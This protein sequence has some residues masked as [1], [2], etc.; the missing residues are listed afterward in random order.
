MGLPDIQRAIEMLS[1][2]QQAALLDWL[3]ERDRRQW[4]AQLERDFSP[5]GAGIELLDRVKAQIRQARILANGQG[6]VNSVSLQ[7][8]ALPEFWK[9]Y[10]ALPQGVRALADAKFA[11][12]EADPFHP[13]LA[14]VVSPRKGNG[15]FAEFVKSPPGV[16]EGGLPV[17][18]NASGGGAAG[19]RSQPEWAAVVSNYRHSRPRSREEVIH[20]MRD[21]SGH[22]TAM[23]QQG[24]RRSPVAYRLGLPLQ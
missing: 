19:S 23:S 13:S 12:F 17:W 9:C 16:T 11:M 21:G 3:A 5:G 15:P 1:S 4:D 8:F 24:R 14:L 7:S 2:D 18:A 10:E 6:L 20:A 22:V